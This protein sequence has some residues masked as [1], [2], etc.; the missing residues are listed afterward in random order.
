MRAAA[1]FSTK[2][3]SGK[4]FLFVKH[5]VRSGL[6]RDDLLVSHFRSTPAERNAQSVW[7]IIAAAVICPILNCAI[8]SA[9]VRFPMGLH[10]FSHGF[11]VRPSPPLEFFESSYGET[12]MKRWILLTNQ[13]GPEHKQNWPKATFVFPLDEYNAFS[14]SERSNVEKRSTKSAVWR[15]KLSSTTNIIVWAPRA[16][17]HYKNN[18]L[19]AKSPQALRIHEFERQELTS[20]TNTLIWMPRAP[21]HYEY[22]ILRAKSS[23]AV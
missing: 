23:Q 18:S 5:Y 17:K 21:R 10:W 19:N 6:A 14:N 9:A 2:T 11:I 12:R 8:S 20:I 15:Q 13:N 1:R 16:P 4:H 22:N 3:S 7:I